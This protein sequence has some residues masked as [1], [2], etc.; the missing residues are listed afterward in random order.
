MQ[1]TGQGAR[2]PSGGLTPAEARAAPT[3]PSPSVSE[4]GTAKTEPTPAQ[5]GL[6]EREALIEFYQ[7]SGGDNWFDKENWLS[8]NYVGQ[9]YGVTHQG[10]GV[11]EIRL[12]DN[13]LEGE[14]TDSWD[15]FPGLIVLD[16]SGNG[17]TGDIPD[18]FASL[19]ELRVLRLD[20]NS[21]TGCLPANISNGL[22]SANT[23]L[24]DIKICPNPERAALEA[25]YHATGGPDWLDNT[26]W[27]TEAPL[28]E[29]FGVSLN[30]DGTVWRL[31]LN[32]NR[33]RGEL[34]SALAELTNLRH[35]H[36][37]SQRGSRISRADFPNRVNRI[38]G[39]IPTWLG[40]LPLETLNLTN[41]GL[42]GSI[43]A[44]LGAMES[45]R[46]LRLNDNELSGP[47]PP[48]LGNLGSLTELLLS[49]NQLSGPI[50]PELGN[51]ASLNSLFIGNNQFSSP[52][53][54]ELGGL[55]ALTD[56]YFRNGGLTGPIPAELGNLAN[57]T[58]LDLSHNQLSGEIPPELGD[59]TSL[60]SLD[61][62][63]NQLSGEIPKHLS[64]IEGLEG[65][66]LASNNL[67][68]SITGHLATLE[69]LS[70]L[71]LSDNVLTGEVPQD[72]GQFPK[73]GRI[74][75]LRTLNLRGNNLEG[76]HEGENAERIRT[77]KC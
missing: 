26:N 66:S 40:E 60:T 64:R 47:I 21:L 13:D 76:C 30:Q 58:R 27:L 46:V 29:W 7:A 12:A 49:G 42:S 3:L 36:L 10:S 39:G 14:I 4:S 55:T 45:L 41:A 62:N 54:P 53:P 32:A 38:S 61:L 17:L 63:N 25:F 74:S 19:T 37:P 65:L 20:G 73:A 50:P 9:W 33:L 68:G 44:E 24:G 34:P 51:L 31:E 59:L 22:D 52:I 72:L 1:D 67:T 70:R 18:S 6:S 8:E 23:R 69:N 77:V 56:L 43:P 57:L 15:S 2:P 71:D 5:P 75:T 48:E 35:L 16:L 11:A 28:G